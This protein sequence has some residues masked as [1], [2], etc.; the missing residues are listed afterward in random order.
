ML[1]FQLI[2]SLLHWLAEPDVP[3]PSP[4]DPL[5]DPDIAAMSARQVADLPFPRST[6]A[7]EYMPVAA[8]VS[9]PRCA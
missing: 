4:E 5:R 9:L 7:N 8:S 3:P 6:Q 1:Q 2:S